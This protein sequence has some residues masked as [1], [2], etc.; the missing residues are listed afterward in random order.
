MHEE[1]CRC[2]PGQ[3]LQVGPRFSGVTQPGKPSQGRGRH[4]QEAFRSPTPPTGQPKLGKHAFW[5][6]S[7]PKAKGAFQSA[8]HNERKH[9]PVSGAA[10]ERLQA[11]CFRL[12]WLYCAQTVYPGACQCR[13]YLEQR[14]NTTDLSMTINMTINIERGG[15]HRFCGLPPRSFPRAAYQIDGFGVGRSQ[16]R[17]SFDIH[18]SRRGGSCRGTCKGGA[19]PTFGIGAQRHRAWP[20]QTAIPSG[21]AFCVGETAPPTS[22][23]SQTFLQPGD[24]NESVELLATGWHLAL[25][26]L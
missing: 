19:R 23:S 4:E 5:P 8:Q 25:T 6:E 24:G 3:P 2:C 16:R 14:S 21:G 11:H 12:L 17:L 10:E 13:H 1:G 18:A 26:C 15:A 20:N 7:T 22:A 9:V